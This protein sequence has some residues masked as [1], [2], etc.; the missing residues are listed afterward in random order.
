MPFG[1][2]RIVH[3]KEV[4]F[5]RAGCPRKPLPI[6]IQLQPF[7]FGRIEALQLHNWEFENNFVAHDIEKSLSALSICPPTNPPTNPL[8]NPAKNSSAKAAAQFTGN[9]EPKPAMENVRVEPCK[10]PSKHAQHFHTIAT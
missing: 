7:K 8:K 6:G 2:K 1:E 3:D 5:V 10:C 4:P 9:S